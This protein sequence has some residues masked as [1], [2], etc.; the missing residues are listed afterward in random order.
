MSNLLSTGECIIF[1]VK[2]CLSPAPLRAIPKISISGSK[3]MNSSSLLIH[4]Q[5]MM[6]MDFKEQPDIHFSSQA[7]AAV[8]CMTKIFSKMIILILIYLF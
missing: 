3:K 6:Q 2:R 8:T 4:V 7:S 1:M 5:L